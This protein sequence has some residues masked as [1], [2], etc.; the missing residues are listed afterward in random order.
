VIVEAMV[1][2]ADKARVVVDAAVATARDT[3][4]SPTDAEKANVAAQQAVTALQKLT[5]SV[6]E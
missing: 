4:K 2:Q 3:S 6:K 1:K 5:T